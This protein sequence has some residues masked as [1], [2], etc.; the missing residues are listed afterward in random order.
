[1][2]LEENNHKK[3]TF[4]YYSNILEEK[5]VE[6]MWCEIIDESKGIYKLDNIP[7]YGPLIASDDIFYAEFDDNEE[8]LV[9]REVIESSG[10]SVVQVV[11]LKEDFDKLLKFGFN[12]K[13]LTQKNIDEKFD[14]VYTSYGVIGWLPD[15][16]NWAKIISQSLKPGGKLI[17]VEFH[18]FVWMFDDNFKEIKYH[19]HNERPIIEEYSGTYANKEADI[20]TDYVGWN[21]SLSEIFTSL[22]KHGLEIQHFE[23]Y[24]YSPYNCF[25]ETIEFEKGKYRIK[26]LDNKIPM[27]FSLIA[28]KK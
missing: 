16:D 1:M 23:E 27:L 24:D 13:Y 21:H 26:H 10:N 4:K 8:G 15:L 25:N 6:T 18:P 2:N 5:T 17:F 11:I 3:I 12:P 22:I 28:N 7:F 9:F 14:I 20:K 19:Y